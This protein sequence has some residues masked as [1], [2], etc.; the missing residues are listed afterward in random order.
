M[1]IESDFYKLHERLYQARDICDRLDQDL[2]D[3]G[4]QTHLLDWREKNGVRQC[5]DRA[6]HLLSIV[7]AESWDILEAELNETR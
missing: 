2:E 1:T 5:L 3:K 4:V 6:I 7:E